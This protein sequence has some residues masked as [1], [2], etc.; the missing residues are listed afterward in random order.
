[1]IK[2]LAREQLKAAEKENAGKVEVD[3]RD[4][5]PD[6]IARAELFKKILQS[7][8]AI[9]SDQ[10][11]A[12]TKLGE[13]VLLNFGDYFGTYIRETFKDGDQVYHSF[14]KLSKKRRQYIQETRAM[15]A[16]QEARDKGKPKAI[17]EPVA[18]SI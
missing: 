8:N 14:R 4:N 18:K 17:G 1:V 11:W 12:E 3:N 2:E 13:I 15:I 10:V 9:V 6:G 7:P 5:S 16:E